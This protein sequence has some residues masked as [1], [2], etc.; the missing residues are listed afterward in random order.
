M[1]QRFFAIIF[2]LLCPSFSVAQSIKIN[3]IMSSNTMTLAD[4]DGEYPDWIEFYNAGRQAIRLKNYGL[5]DDRFEPLKWRF[6]DIRL[7]P[8][9]FLLVFASGKDIRT[10]PTHRETVIDWGDSWKFLLPESE[11]PAAW[12]TLAFNDSAWQNG[13]SGFGYGD[14]DDATDIGPE[15]PF[16]APPISIFVRK[17][18]QITAPEDVVAAILHVDYDDGFV[19]YLNGV[20]IARA[21]LGFFNTPPAFNQFADDDHEAQMY[22]GGAPDRFV[23]EDIQSILQTGKN[24]LAIQCHNC[25]LYSSD[26]TLIPFLTLEMT[27]PPPDARG[28]SLHLNFPPPSKLHTN[29]KINSDGEFVV[30]SDSFGA[31]RDS[32][33]TSKI[34]A[35]HSRGRQPDGSSDWLLFPEPTPGFSNTT[36]GFKKVAPVPDFSVQGGI[37]NNSFTVELTSSL[38]GTTIRFTRDG[39]I[40]HDTSRAYTSPILLENTTVLR[41]RVFGTEMVPGETVT[42][43][44]F[45]NEDFS[46]PVVSLATDPANFWDNEMGIYVFGDNADTLNYP[47]WGSNF[48][49]DWERP[50]HIEFFETD[51]RRMFGIDAGVKIFGS[52]SRLYPQKSLAI[53][54]RGRYGEDRM[55]HPIFPDKAISAYKSIILRNSGQDWGRTFFRDAFL[56]DLV[57]D[58]DLDIQAYRP[59]LVFL[60]GEFFG[61]HN[62]REKMN[63]HY[64][65]SNRGVDPE[66]IDFIERDEMVIHGDARHYQNLLGFVSTHDLADPAAYEY[67]TTQMDIDNFIFYTLTVNYYANSDWPWNNV[68][69][70]RPR[71]ADGKWKWLLFDLDYC[72]HGGHLGPE[73]NVFSEMRN[74][75]NGLTLLFFNLLKNYTFRKKFVNYFADHINYTFAPERILPIIEQFK[76]G[77]ENE[78]PRH[79]QK[80]QHSFSGPWWLG[81][82]IDSMEEWYDHIEVPKEFARERPAHVRRQLIEEFDLSD[83]GQAS[84]SLS[85][86]PA[87]AGKIQ[88]NSLQ[89]DTFPWSGIYFP[90]LPIRLT[91]LPNSGYRFIRWEGVSAADSFSIEFLFT[92]DQHVVAVFEKSNLTDHPIVINE[93]NYKSAAHFDTEDWVEIHNPG[94]NA[95]DISGW[96]FKDSENSHVFTFPSGT[97]LNVGQFV[98]LSRDTLTFRQFHPNVSPLFG[99]M[100]FGLSSDGEVV[101]LFDANGE[102]I[103]SLTFGNESPWPETPNGDGPTLELIDPTAENSQPQ[104][105]AASKPIG[106][107]PGAPNSVWTGVELSSVD[108]T[109]P[110]T[111][112]LFQNFPNPFNAQTRIRFELPRSAQVTLKIYSVLGEEIATLLSAVRPAGQYSIHWD[113]TDRNGL[114]VSS[115]VFFYRLEAGDFCGKGKL[116]LLR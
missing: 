96:R 76:T 32:L 114:P 79:I 45:I 36:A 39:S 87:D 105:W 65:A 6:P 12:R 59:A 55:R 3:E 16:E 73:A 34:P 9:E 1:Y 100:D 60:N 78:M 44:Y 14:N 38:P 5:S 90:D 30:L 54:A 108:R 82:S 101:R 62:I 22:A 52:W 7:E 91:A 26:L 107:T 75:Q 24:V 28:A 72:F 57:K 86:S 17:E 23:I 80:W 37:F 13:A 70:W 109:F 8:G 71:T 47:Y 77:I 111:F 20:E 83:G 103:D 51:G 53:F 88:I 89:V 42:Q 106:G 49:E 41:A 68:K 19:A 115:G 67:V 74:Q 29:F 2:L 95:V 69:C 94:L 35:D 31:V 112:R 84:I 56:H 110:S 50:L 116:V 43:T 4:A 113:G 93:I 81:K 92:N 11:P 18:L 27:A 102:L 25:Q 61:L 48:W 33:F 66:N 63:E 46:L 58:S 10:I 21:N 99:N 97:I 40:P 64:L 85:V 98:V 104:N 15:D